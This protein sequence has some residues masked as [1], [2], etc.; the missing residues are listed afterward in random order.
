MLARLGLS[1]LLAIAMLPAALSSQGR[2]PSEEYRLKAAFVYRFPQFVEWPAPAL[3]GH[4]SLTICVLRPNPF[5]SL[6]GEL[7]AGE[8]LNGRS[9]TIREIDRASAITGCHVVFVPGE[10]PAAAKAVLTAAGQ[11]PI[12]TVGESPR[13]LDDG[14]VINLRVVDRRVRFEISATAAERAG[15]RLSSQLLQLAIRVTG[16]T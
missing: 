3:D 9:L 14:G 12:L 7:I 10:Q 6:L 4:E 15:L 1:G 5:G 16:A 8:T 13:F 2:Q 11:H